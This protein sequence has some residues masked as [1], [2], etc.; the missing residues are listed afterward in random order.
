MLFFDV[1]SRLF[2]CISFGEYGSCLLIFWVRLEKRLSCRIRGCCFVCLA[3][4]RLKMFG[5]SV[6]QTP[7]IAS[8][9]PKIQVLSQCLHLMNETSEI[10]PNDHNSPPLSSQNP[11]KSQ[12]A[13][14]PSHSILLPNYYKPTQVP[15]QNYHSY[16]VCPTSTL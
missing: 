13:D 9:A 15:Q 6:P 3:K 14:F 2:K 10:P 5:T 8:K 12:S 7:K 11:S 4:E 1:M 16:K